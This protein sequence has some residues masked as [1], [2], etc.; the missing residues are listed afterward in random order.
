MGEREEERSVEINLIP[1]NSNPSLTIC[2]VVRYFFHH[3]YFWYCGPMA[4]NM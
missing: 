1:K 3:R 4:E 2:R